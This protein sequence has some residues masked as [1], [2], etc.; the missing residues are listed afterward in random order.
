LIATVMWLH[1][2][3]ISVTYRRRAVRAEIPKIFFLRYFALFP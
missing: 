3:M 2:V 1:P